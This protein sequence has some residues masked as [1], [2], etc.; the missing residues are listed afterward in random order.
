MW[1][2]P[3]A[4]LFG[5]CLVHCRAGT[6][7]CTRVWA[8]PRLLP[9]ALSRGP[10]RSTRLCGNL[11]LRAQAPSNCHN[12]SLVCVGCVLHHVLPRVLPCI[13]TAARSPH[14]VDPAAWKL[15]LERVGPKL[16]IV[17]AAAD[18]NDWRNHLDEARRLHTV[19]VWYLPRASPNQ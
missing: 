13:C 5:Y 2:R 8:L 9:F 7:D 1:V 6:A 14:Q 4:L 15:E 10:P 11:S 16:R 18:A 19:G 12:Y 17:M 3:I